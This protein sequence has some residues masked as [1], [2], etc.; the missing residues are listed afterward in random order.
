MHPVAIYSKSNENELIETSICFIS[1]DLN[2]DLCLVYQ[3]LSDTVKFV[4]QN[5]N[6][7]VSMIHYFSDGCAGQYKN[8]KN[9]IN[10]CLHKNDF[11]IN[12][13]WNFFATSHGKSPCDA[14]GTV[15]WVTS[16]ASLQRTIENQILSVSDMYHFCKE[17][18]TGI[19]F[20]QIQ[21]QEM[22]NVRDFLNQRFESKGIN[23][24]TRSFHQYVPLGQLIIGCER[25]SEDDDFVLQHE[26]TP[27]HTQNI[28]D[29]RIS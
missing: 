2:H 24:G 19:H 10:L 12:C 26:L 15:K 4:K 29:L 22:V 6:T 27:N 1:D 18:I 16:K 9:F 28:P 14:I 20:F 3:I 13:S 25:V 17:T 8:C 23:P 11:S 21:A 7:N 5:M